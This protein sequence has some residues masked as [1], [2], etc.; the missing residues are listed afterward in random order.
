MLVVS[1]CDKNFKIDFKI[2]KI[3]SSDYEDEHRSKN[4]TVWNSELL[5]FAASE[6]TVS[7]QKGTRRG[8]YVIN[9][10]TSNL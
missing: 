5:H 3:C 2:C 10:A 9:M 7:P 8:Q 4:R 6:V 1:L